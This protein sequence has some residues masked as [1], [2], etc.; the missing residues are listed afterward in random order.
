MVRVKVLKEWGPHK[1][2]DFVELQ[3]KQIRAYVAKGLVSADFETTALTP[4]KTEASV[5]EPKQRKRRKR[6]KRFHQ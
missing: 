1:V 5:A 4:E 6:K 3:E 2:G